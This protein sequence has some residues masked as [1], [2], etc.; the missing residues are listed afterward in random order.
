[1]ESSAQLESTAMALQIQAVMTSVEELTKQN[2]EMRQQL[3]QEENCLP[4]RIEN[5]ENQ[6]EAQDSKGSQ[7]RVDSR[8]TERF[9]EESNNLLRSMRR[10]LDKLKNA[11]KEKM[12]KNLDGM[13]WVKIA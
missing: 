11:M 6:D 8:R 7:G 2:Q 13:C 1:M 10:E 3:Q 5:N 4:R 12:A 9:D